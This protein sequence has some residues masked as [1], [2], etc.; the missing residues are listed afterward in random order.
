[1]F[2]Q[3]GPCNHDT[4]AENRKS[5]PAHPQDV[6]EYAIMLAVVLVIVLGTVRMIGA[7]G[8]AQQRETRQNQRAEE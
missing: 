6:A 1:M 8:K 7:I 4:R 3:R 2:C 5:I